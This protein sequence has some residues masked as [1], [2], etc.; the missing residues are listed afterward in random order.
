MR[1]CFLVFDFGL[2]RSHAGDPLTPRDLY[3][4]ERLRTAYLVNGRNCCGM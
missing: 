3:H 2:V 4:Q 1:K